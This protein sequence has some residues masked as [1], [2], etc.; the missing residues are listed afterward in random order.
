MPTKPIDAN[1]VADEI[2]AA[3]STIE[4]KFPG[5]V[6]PQSAQ[7]AIRVL[8]HCESV[9][10]RLELDKRCRV[11][12]VHLDEGV[13]GACELVVSELLGAKGERLIESYR[14]PFSVVPISGKIPRE[15]RIEHTVRLFIDDINIVRLAPG[16]A[17]RGGYVDVVKAVHR[18]K[19]TPAEMAFD[20]S[21]ARVEIDQRLAEVAQRRAA[22]YGRI[23]ET[24]FHRIEQAKESDRVPIVIWPRLE[25]SSAP[26]EKA[27]DR[28]SLERPAEEKKVDARIRKASADLRTALQR[29]KIEVVRE[30]RT[31]ETVPCVRASATV[32]QIRSLAENKAVGVILFDDV[33]EITD[34]GDSI[35]VARSDRAH[36]A[37]FDGTGIRVAVFESGPSVTTNLVFAGRF[38]NSPPASDHARL[39]SAV[40]KNVEAQQA[41]RSRTGLRSILREHARAT[42]RCAGPSRIS[43]ARSS[44]RA[45]TAAASRA[46]P[47]CR[48]MTC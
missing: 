34:L 21:G 46:A 35:A 30:K 12:K 9:R 19:G 39:T 38:T 28:P 26:Y 16:Q 17:S 36:A 1:I 37:G 10:T 7:G 2:V 32:K 27:T 45:S 25:L 23:H 6:D 47:A 3:G 5:P 8:H 43:T 31:D 24:L 14:L 48:R 29:A 4:L 20:H 11:L 13:V 42:T 15:M 18:T 40:V 44:A 41:A 22:K 33:S